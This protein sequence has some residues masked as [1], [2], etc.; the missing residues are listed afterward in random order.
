MGYLLKNHDTTQLVEA[1]RAAAEGAALVST[2]VTPT[3]LREF[4]RRRDAGPVVPV[5][6][7]GVLSGAS[8][9]WRAH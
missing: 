2:H 6:S 7:T 5:P 9:S 3:L 1:I 4:T 8:S